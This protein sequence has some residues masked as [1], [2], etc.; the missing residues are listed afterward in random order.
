MRTVP[1]RALGAIR[2]PRRALRLPSR[3]LR[4]PTDG[5]A[6]RA[7]R[8]GLLRD[9]RRHV[10]RARRALLAVQCGARNQS[11]HQDAPPPVHAHLRR[12]DAHGRCRLRSLCQ[13]HRRQGARRAGLARAVAHV[14]GGRRLQGHR[15]TQVTRGAA[16]SSAWG[17]SFWHMGCDARYGYHEVLHLTTLLGHI[18]GLVLDCWDLAIPL[19]A[20]PTDSS[21]AAMVSDALRATAATIGTYFVDDAVAA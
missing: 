3:A 18:F 7:R 9:Q 5:R 12:A 1:W 14:C 16:A 2:A 20:P 6:A 4:R 19:P 10:R 21:T 15:A 8:H 11:A 17:C 13:P